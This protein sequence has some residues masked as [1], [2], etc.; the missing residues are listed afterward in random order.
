MLILQPNELR[1]YYRTDD[2]EHPVCPSRDTVLLTLME[3][4]GFACH[5]TGVDVE[6][7]VRELYFE[8]RDGK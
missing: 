4:I 5:T 2:P 3:A 8:K 6:N 7:H 1:I